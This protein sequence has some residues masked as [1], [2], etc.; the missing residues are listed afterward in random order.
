MTQL[1]LEP[2]WSRL[3]IHCQE[4][5]TTRNRQQM[6]KSFLDP[7]MWQKCVRKDAICVRSGSGLP[8]DP[9]ICARENRCSRVRNRAG[10]LSA[11]RQDMTMLQAENSVL[12]G[13]FQ[14]TQRGKKWAREIDDYRVDYPLSMRYGASREWRTGVTE[15]LPRK[16]ARRWTCRQ[17]EGVADIRRRRR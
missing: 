7:P 8:C 13:P 5:G 10:Q 14:T 16:L 17:C 3:L 2:E 6:A 4:V 1:S 12:Q 15:P 9:V 11:R